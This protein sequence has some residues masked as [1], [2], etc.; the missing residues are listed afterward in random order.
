MER[1]IKRILFLSGL[2]VLMCCFYSCSKDD[3]DSTASD[4]RVTALFVKT[5]YYVKSTTG[6][7]SS[8]TSDDLYLVTKLG[9][10]VIVKK[11]TTSNTITYTEIA[12]ALESHYANNSNVKD[13]FKNNAGTV[14]IDCRN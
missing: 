4:S 7:G 10:L 11:N 12:T 6:A 9:K 8:K 13:V 2:I 14:T 1:S 5:D 3:D